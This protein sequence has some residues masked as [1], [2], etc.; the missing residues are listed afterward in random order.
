MY[1]PLY[2]GDHPIE[3]IENELKQ[4]KNADNIIY[5]SL[6]RLYIK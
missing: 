2:I 1:L 5:F 6:I 4:N 3:H